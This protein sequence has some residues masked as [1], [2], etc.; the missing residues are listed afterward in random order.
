MCDARMTSRLGSG[1]GL[2]VPRRV[3]LGARLPLEDGQ[4]LTVGL[5][6]GKDVELG[7]RAEQRLL[8]QEQGVTCRALQ[9]I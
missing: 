7:R 4:E 3:V 5:L 6:E 1:G 8:N 2:M 9:E